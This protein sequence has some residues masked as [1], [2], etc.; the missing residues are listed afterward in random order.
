VGGN[1]SGNSLHGVRLVCDV[2]RFTHLFTSHC[3]DVTRCVARL[4]RGA[5]G[6][7]FVVYYTRTY[8][9][10]VRSPARGNSK[11]FL[12][13]RLKRLNP[14]P[15]TLNPKRFLVSRLGLKRSAT[16]TEHKSL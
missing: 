13:S 9:K 3:F 5:G 8:Y 6:E 16:N 1:Q 15:E 7:V 2:T 11:R 4:Q 14:E 12:V 10:A